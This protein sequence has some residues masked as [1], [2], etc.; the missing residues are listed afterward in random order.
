MIVPDLARRHVGDHGLGAVQHAL[1]ID[2]DLAGKGLGLDIGEGARIGHAGIVDQAGGLAEFLLGVADGALQRGIVGDIGRGIG[3]AVGR[4]SVHRLH[5]S[6]DQQQ[7]VAL[8]GKGAGQGEADAGA[9]SG[10]DDERSGH[11]WSF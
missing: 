11:G 1:Q 5:V 3:R 7:G 4:Q 2:V 10:D 9:R 6:G 8:L